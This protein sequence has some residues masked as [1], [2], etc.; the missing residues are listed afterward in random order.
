ME[1]ASYRPPPPGPWTSPNLCETYGDTTQSCVSQ[2]VADTC[3][4]LAAKG[5][6]ELIVMESCPVQLA[7]ATTA[8]PQEEPT[9]GSSCT[10]PGLACVVAEYTCPGTTTPITTSVAEC[11]NDGKWQVMMASIFCPEQTLSSGS[12]AAIV[13]GGCVLAAALVAAFVVVSRSRRRR[14]T[15]NMTKGIEHER[16][17]AIS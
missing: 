9:P 6:I 10:A 2:A 8:C 4:R 16:S 15:G 11:A 13:V 3:T 1:G 7:C 17:M 5:C 14:P 12:I